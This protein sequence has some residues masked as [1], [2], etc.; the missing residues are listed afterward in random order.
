MIQHHKK[1]REIMMTREEEPMNLFQQSPQL[2]SP[3][4]F[5]SETRDDEIVVDVA[6]PEEPTVKKAVG[7]GSRKKHSSQSRLVG[8]KCDSA[9]R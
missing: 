5:D 7:A 8:N 6:L 9:R 1:Q 4:H 2:L 3:V